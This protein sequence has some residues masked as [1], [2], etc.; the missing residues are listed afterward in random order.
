MSV[1]LYWYKIN[2]M[3]STAEPYMFILVMDLELPSMACQREGRNSSTASRFLL[4]NQYC[5][6]PV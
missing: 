3:V 6:P 1:E 4:T 2:A 5:Q